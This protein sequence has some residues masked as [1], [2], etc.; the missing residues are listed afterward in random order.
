M[1]IFSSVLEVGRI[2]GGGLNVTGHP[3]DLPPLAVRA[4]AGKFEP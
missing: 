2:W 4:T 3:L 1:S